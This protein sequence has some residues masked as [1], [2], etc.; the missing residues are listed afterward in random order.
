MADFGSTIKKCL[1][2]M[3]SVSI[4]VEYAFF[5]RKSHS[6]SIGVKKWL[7]SADF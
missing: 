2:I 3:W 1:M 7:V 4:D 5:I 6:L